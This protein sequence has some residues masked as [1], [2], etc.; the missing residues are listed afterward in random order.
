MTRVWLY[1]WEWDCC[2]DRFAVGDHVDLGIESR[3]PNTGLG[4]L[5]GPEIAASVDA[6]ESH[7]EHEFTDRVRGRVL[8]VHDV[9]H[10]VIERR[11]LRRPG[12]GAAMD[13]V[14]P[15]DGEEWPMVGRV[16]GN[17]VFLGFR[18][19]RYMVEIVSVPGTAALEP[20][21]GIGLGTP[22][23]GHSRA[24]SADAPPLERRRRAF[25]G[26]LVDIDEDEGPTGPQ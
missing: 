14:M 7:H 23:A 24:T 3:R 25:A 6:A 17:G 10:D 13:A 9:T 18:P 20:V 1:S 4:E 19:T 11:T 5:L 21:P 15:A 16:L 12:H 22:A 26:W 2:G 8:A